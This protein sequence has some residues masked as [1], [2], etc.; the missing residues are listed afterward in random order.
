MQTFPQTHARG[1]TSIKAQILLILGLLGFGYLLL[2]TLVQFT[3]AATHDHIDHASSSLF[4]AAL[5]LQAAEAAFADLQKRYKDAVLLEDPEAV[6][7]AGKD[8]E[9]VARSLANLKALV[10]TSPPLSANA[11]ELISRFASIRVRSQE[12]YSDML[13]NKSGIPG[14]L[15]EK[16]AA[17]AIDNR[18]LA[19]SMTRLDSAVA[20][21]FRGE[22]GLIDEWSQR[23]RFTGW[24][25]L[26]IAIAVCI[27]AWSVLR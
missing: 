13:A 21:Q 6:A 4:P 19:V 18:E 10:S 26:L 5:Q 11:G 17:L 25:M 8:A 27:G 2:L 23:S 9:V 20:V 16:A 7:A 3:A 1:W 15:R 24:C 22:L 12:T 14:D